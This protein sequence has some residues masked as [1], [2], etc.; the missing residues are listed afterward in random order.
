MYT[1]STLVFLL[2][3]YFIFFHLFMKESKGAWLPAA[4]FI[5]LSHIVIGLYLIFYLGSVIFPSSTYFLPPLSHPGLYH[6]S[7]SLVLCTLFA[8]W[9]NLLGITAGYH[10][11]WSHRSYT[12]TVPL[13]IF[14]SIIGLMSFQGSA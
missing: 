4:V 9:L 8:T 11:L 1:H 14:L 10:R 3:T 7:L 5:F 6:P 2:S 13:R 12:A